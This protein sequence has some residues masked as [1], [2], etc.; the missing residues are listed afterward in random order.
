MT[1]SKIKILQIIHLAVAGSLLMFGAVVYY[2]LNYGGGAISEL[3][4]D[5][6]RRIVPITIILCMTAAYYFKKTM[7]RKAQSQRDQENKWAEYQK[8]IVTELAFLELPGLVSIVA[9]LLSGEI[10]FL[11]VGIALI[12]V[13][14]FRRP[15]ERKI[16]TDL[17]G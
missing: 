5:M 3:S 10:N 17:G 7:L 1:S 13:I 15:T 8:A 4:P 2:L 14:L 9:A 11:L 6:F 16:R 12:A